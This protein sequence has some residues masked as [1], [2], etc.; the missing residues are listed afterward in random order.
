MPAIKLTKFLGISPKASPEL[1]AESVAQEAVNVKLYSGDLIPYRQPVDVQTLMRS[2]T[3]QSIYPMRDENDETVN[4]WLSWLGDIDIA[5]ASSLNE[6]EQRIYYTGDGVPKVTDYSLAI[7]GSGPYPNGSYDLGL[8][9]P[10]TVPIATEVSHAN[11]GITS[12]ARD[13]GNIATIITDSN[14]ELR[15]G[16]KITITGHTKITGTY[17]QSAST[18]VTITMTGHGF[19][20]GAQV[21]LTYTSGDAND[22]LYTATVTGV[23]TFTVIDPVDA[24]TSGNV[25]ISIREYNVQNAEVTVVDPDEFTVFSSG[26]EQ[27]TYTIGDGE[28][29]LSG[30]TY[31]RA[32]I[33]TWITPWGEE[34]VPSEPSDF[35]YIKDGQ[36]VTVSGLPS[37]GPAGNYQVMG[38]NVY[39]TVS[40]NTSSVYKKV[41]ICWFPI[42][43]TSASRTSNV[44]TFVC[45]TPHNLIVGDLV[46]TANCEFGT[47]VDATFDE[48]DE[49]VLSTPDKWTFTIASVGTDKVDTALVDGTLYWK[50]SSPGA[51]TEL[52][53]EGTTLSD[54]YDV[55][56]LGDELDS[57][58]ADAPDPGMIGIKSIQNNMLAGHVA[59]ELCFSDPG[60][61]WSWPERYRLTF[62]SEIIAIETVSGSVLVLTDR[63]P[64]MVQGS[65]PA[66]MT[67]SRIDIVMPC[68]SKRSVVNMG[69]GVAYA[70][71]GG[72]ALYSSQGPGYVTQMVHDWDTWTVEG[73]LDPTSI[74]ASFYDGK[75][76]GAHDNGTMIF[77]ADKK[78]GGMMTTTPTKMYGVYY[79]PE[80][81][82]MYYTSD[83]NGTLSEW[84][85]VGQPSLT[86][87]WKSK[88]FVTAGYQNMGAARVVADYDGTE[89]E[90]AAI[91]AYN[92]T[93][94]AYNA[95]IWALVS[96]LGSMN[97]VGTYTDP[98]TAQVIAPSGAFN[99][100][101]INGDPFLR[102]ELSTEGLASTTFQL[103]ADKASKAERTI[104][105][106]AIFRLPTGYKTDTYEVAVTGTVRIRAIHLGETPYG[107]RVV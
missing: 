23:N 67:P 62:E 33:Y 20:S 61:P 15:T 29:S 107:L 16:N 35:I 106:S 79:D 39:R 87:S 38:I 86:M 25:E 103:W 2:G 85:A 101:A 68:I 17:D 37:A 98:D 51:A 60:K 8:P 43:M 96:D 19:S 77:E 63:H 55:N 30:N 22:G 54:T 45:P 73:Q 50:V 81:S 1:T 32:Y 84:D 31:A 69:Y 6:E 36:T 72:L 105:T 70:S 56:E 59:N 89:D 44:A 82:R 78:T 49:A 14:H 42:D 95:N 104:G 92:L 99:E 65:T 88:V 9:L 41:S 27:D 24:T 34:S 7:V 75:Y 93:V 76:L 57:L 90:L 91:V 5:V 3:I 80:Y 26:P 52:Y 74:R 53:Y 40:G 18:T 71:H 13:T 11:V 64:H 83:T 47:G 97:G 66:N 21:S 48:T 100:I 58:Y 46:K 12:V 28:V 10:T 4:K 94:A 102:E